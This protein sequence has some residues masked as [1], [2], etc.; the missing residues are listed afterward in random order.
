MKNK[1]SKD[2]IKNR[3]K[4]FFIESAKYGRNRVKEDEAS[5]NIKE[6][7]DKWKKDKQ[8]LQ[9]PEEETDQS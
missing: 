2:H 4:W 3:I 1:K 6:I 9:D 5:P 7:D 8:N